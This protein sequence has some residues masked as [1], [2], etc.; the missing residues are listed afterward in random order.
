MEELALNDVDLGGNGLEFHRQAARGFVDEVDG[1]VGEEAVG[2]VARGELGG[3]DERGVLDLDLVV[4]FVA[5]LQAA[6]DRDG[7]FDRR[8]ADVNGLEAPL[9]RGV[10]FDVL[11]VFVE[12]CRAD[13][14]EFAASERGLEEIG[15]VH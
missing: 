13:A 14:A 10:F 12:R 11:A 8:L 3:G 15:G 2:D 9:K 6:E 4:D 5:L 7:V 1:L